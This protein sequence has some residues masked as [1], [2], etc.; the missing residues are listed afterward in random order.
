MQRTF[1]W[2]I[3]DR[4][5]YLGVAN[6]KSGSLSWTG[7]MSRRGRGAY[8]CGWEG[9]LENSNGS[10]S[11]VRGAVLSVLNTRTMSL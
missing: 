10:V 3:C 5:R 1:Q 4:H 2:E 9:H 7:Y 8:R 6:G 11:E